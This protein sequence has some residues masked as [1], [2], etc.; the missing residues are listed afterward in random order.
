[1]NRQ[2]TRLTA[3]CAMLA[4]ASLVILLLA[5]GVPSGWLGMTA[6]AGLCTGAACCAGGIPAGL[7]T[8][9]VSGL[10]SVLLLPRKEAALLYAV[11]FGLYPVLKAKI[12]S[13]R[14]LWQEWLWKLAAGN[15]LMAGAFLLVGE[16]LTEGVSLPLPVLWAGA[17]GVFVCYDYAFSRVMTLVQNRLMPLLRRNRIP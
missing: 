15:A 6:A 7:G 17:N 10:L 4:A 11:L 3:L 9:A 2:R 8:W 5:C 1:M 16:V 14:S 12:E 13:L